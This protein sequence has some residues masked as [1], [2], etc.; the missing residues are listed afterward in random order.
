MPDNA[1]SIPLPEYEKHQDRLALINVLMD[2]LPSLKEQSSEYLPQE[3]A[4][5]QTAYK[6]RV[7]R[8]IDFT[9]FYE[10]TLQKMVGEVF[11]KDLVLGEDVPSEIKSLCENIDMQGKNESRFAQEVFKA[12][13]KDGITHILVDYPQADGLSTRAEELAAGVRPYWVHIPAS[14]LIGWKHAMIAGRPVLTQVRFTETATE[15]DPKDPYADK[16]VNRIRVMTVGENNGPVVFEVW[17]E[18]KGENDQV[19]WVQISTG[20][21]TLNFIPLVT[22]T[23]GE[24]ISL[25]TAKPPLEGVAT[26]NLSHWQLYS[27]YK[28]TLHQMV[29]IWFGK[30]IMDSQGACLG[31]DGCQV[32]M[33]AG[34]I[35]STSNT[36]ASLEG[37]T[38]DGAPA[39]AMLKELRNIED[40]IAL[41]GLTLMLPKT[42]QVTA[43][44]AGQDKGENDSALRGWA[45]LLK[46]CLELALTYT[47][48]WL[49]IGDSGGSVA[50]NTDF[51]VFA[52]ADLDSIGKLV[53]A[54]KL[55]VE[56]Y[57]D[58]AKR[59][60][61]MMD[62][63][64]AADIM[65]MLENQL[66][67]A[68]A[69]NFGALAEEVLRRGQA[70]PPPS[71]T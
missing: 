34:R 70:G 54:G 38:L 18:R 61:V 14:R 4:E 66:R 40:K 56:V 7:R 67:Q 50:V 53:I 48:K 62:S 43:T 26:L 57:I 9:P 55:P 64:D 46:D 37:I 3:P 23:A 13:L 20:S 35:I 15:S 16:T 25:M 12:A 41:F 19:D 17:E 6:L 11:S 27:D 32:V 1:V 42:G 44:Q 51:K 21:I 28:Q 36:E 22:I 68:G 63:W 47:A 24:A 5:S 69:A 45:M 49:K 8:S 60:G 33:S 65:A 2:G 71:Q 58:E 31:E 29:P 59:R 30:G 10:R 39:E 52:I